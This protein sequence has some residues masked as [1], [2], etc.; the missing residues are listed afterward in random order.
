MADPSELSIRR[1]PKGIRWRGSRHHLE[2]CYYGFPP[3]FISIIQH[4]HDNSSCEVIHAGVLMDT[5]QVQTSVHQ[6]CLLSPTKFLLVVDWIMSR[7]HQTRRPASDGLSPNSWRT[8]TS[9]TTLASSH[10]DIRM[11]RRSCPAS[12][13]KLR[14]RA[15]ISTLRPRLH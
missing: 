3:K 1:L 2:A 15:P 14:R 13:K 6:G 7:Q 4:L 10:T 12:P 5:L 8:W 9:L 11:H